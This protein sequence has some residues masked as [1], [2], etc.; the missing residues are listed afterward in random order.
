MRK[1]NPKQNQRFTWANVLRYGGYHLMPTNRGSAM[2]VL[3]DLITSARAAN[4]GHE[5]DTLHDLLFAE[6]DTLMGKGVSSP[7]EAEALLRFVEYTSN[8]GPDQAKA[9]QAI[10]AYMRQ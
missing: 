9:I 8:I 2:T 10:R 3:S 6:A 5:A 1:Q 4:D 7:T